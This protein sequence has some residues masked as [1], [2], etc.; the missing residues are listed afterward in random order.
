MKNEN[1]ER[2]R[3]LIDHRS[4]VDSRCRFSYRPM[5]LS[6]FLTKI[7]SKNLFCSQSAFAV[8][9]LPSFTEFFFQHRTTSCFSSSFR[10][11]DVVK[12]QSWVCLFWLCEF[13][14]RVSRPLGLTAAVIH[15]LTYLHQFLISKTRDSS[16]RFCSKRRRGDR[17]SIKVK[18]HTET[19]C[20]MHTLFNSTQT[21]FCKQLGVVEHHVKRENSPSTI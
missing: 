7:E 5:R 18:Y 17:V 3:K 9:K 11:F 14:A 16:V 13:V 4:T 15:L 1:D 21:L 12:S 2:L 19:T 20:S 6:H 8:H 10:R